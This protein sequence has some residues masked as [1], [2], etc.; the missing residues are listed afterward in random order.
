MS[1]IYHSTLAQ[2]L[3]WNLALPAGGEHPDAHISVM[4]SRENCGN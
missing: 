1:L 3:K 4:D 2:N